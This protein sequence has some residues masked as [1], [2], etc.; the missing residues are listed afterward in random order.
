MRQEKAVTMK[1]P[2][3]YSVEGE[4]PKLLIVSGEIDLS[5]A[6]RLAG[7][8]AE[9]IDRGHNHLVLDLALVEFLDS[10]GIGILIGA[11]HR[12]EDVGGTMS[13]QTA[14]PRVRRVLEL[15]GLDWLL[16][17][18]EPAGGHGCVS[19][20]ALVNGTVKTT[21]R[22]AEAWTATCAPH[23]RC[24]DL[25]PNQSLGLPSRSTEANSARSA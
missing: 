11:R 21:T 19:Q 17:E 9:L 12:L 5:T 24:H 20:L 4:D 23:R 6:P 13:I 15:V 10:T 8:I 2:F 18:E 25:L 14:G 16:P 22:A 3:T 7:A 1:T